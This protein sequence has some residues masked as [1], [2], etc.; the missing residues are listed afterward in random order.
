MSLIRGPLMTGAYALMA[1]WL[2]IASA[3]RIA[4]TLNTGDAIDPVTFI[5]GAIGLLALLL[6]I[7]AWDEHHQR[8]ADQ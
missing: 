5:S 6:L 2:V 1:G 8:K 3:R 7:P 4:L